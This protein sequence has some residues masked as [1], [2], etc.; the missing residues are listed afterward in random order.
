MRKTPRQ[1]LASSEIELHSFK[2]MLEAPMAAYAET[3]RKRYKEH[4]STAIPDFVL[5]YKPMRDSMLKLIAQGESLSDII[6]NVESAIAAVNDE[7]LVKICRIFS[8][9]NIEAEFSIKKKVNEK[10]IFV[11]TITTSKDLAHQD[12]S[13]T[14]CFRSTMINLNF[15]SSNFARAD[16]RFADCGGSNF[17][18][19][20]FRC[21][22]LRNGHFVNT[23]FTS[24]DLT[25]VNLVNANLS[26]AILT[27]ADLSDCCLEGANLMGVDWT[28][29]RMNVYTR[30]DWNLYGRDILLQNLNATAKFTEKNY[31]EKLTHLIFSKISSR[32]ILTRLKQELTQ[33]LGEPDNHYAYAFIS[34]VNFNDF[35]LY[36]Q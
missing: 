16:L 24:A 30:L 13:A 2:S 36:P 11:F 14:N 34:P 28:A 15:E 4:V 9:N 35:Q 5:A 1:F 20:N 26:H 29:I 18:H 23:D 33:Q 19:A 6:S 10:G 22:D 27:H 12:F 7:H 8:L 25:M 17:S 21:A 31:F 3:Y 32:D